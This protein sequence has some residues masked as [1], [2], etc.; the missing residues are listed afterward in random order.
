MGRRFESCPARRRLPRSEADEAL[1]LLRRPAAVP[2]ASR[3]RQNTRSA[4]IFVAWQSF[5]GELHDGIG[6]TWMKGTRLPSDHPSV[7]K[8]PEDFRP[9]G[10]P[11]DE[12]P[13]PQIVA[14]EG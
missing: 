8:W 13:D 14:L 12:M 1:A 11:S 2:C 3:G 5:A 10:T 7:K 4:E 9:D 6:Y